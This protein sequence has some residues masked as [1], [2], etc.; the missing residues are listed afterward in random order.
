MQ[1]QSSTV[2]TRAGK[3]IKHECDHMVPILSDYNYS[4]IEGR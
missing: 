1:T 4:D 2:N 3:Y